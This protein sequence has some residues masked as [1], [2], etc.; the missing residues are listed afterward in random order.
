[1]GLKYEKGVK[2]S[3]ESLSEIAGVF[4]CCSEAERTATFEFTNKCP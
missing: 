4:D 1:M 2:E 3:T